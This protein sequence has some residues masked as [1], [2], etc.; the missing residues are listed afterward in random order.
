VGR[1]TGAADCEFLL[2]MR[3]FTVRLR[4]VL[5][6]VLALLL[7][8]QPLARARSIV[9][10]SATAMLLEDL[11]VTICSVHGVMAPGP[12]GLPTPAPDPENPACP[13]CGLSTGQSP[14]LPWIAAVPIGVLT[15]PRQLHA[16]MAA[17]APCPL[18][19]RRARAACSP[20][21]PPG[22]LSP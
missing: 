1:L 18:P 4:A 17:S 2:G 7:A 10:S 3:C 5:L 13:W 12:D 20:R 22:G 14:Q 16:A 21:A 15:P 6:V 11:Q 8:G 9:P 19:P